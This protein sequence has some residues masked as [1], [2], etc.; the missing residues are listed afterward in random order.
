MNRI[1]INITLIVLAFFVAMT[2]PSCSNE[3]IV[4]PTPPTPTNN[5]DDPFKDGEL[6]I[7]LPVTRAINDGE[8]ENIIQTARLIVIKNSIVANNKTFTIVNGQLAHLDSVYVLDTIPVGK[9]DMFI[10]VNEKT[11]WGLASITKNSIYF[12]DDISKKTLA[13]SAYPA[14]DATHPIPMYKQYRDLHISNEGAFTPAGATAPIP[15]A[16]LGEVERLYAKVT[17]VL[18][19]KFSEMLNGGDPIKID[20]IS[21]KSMP[22]QSYLTPSHGLL[23]PAA[24]GGYFDGAVHASIVSGSPVG[25][26]AADAV[27][28]Y[29]SLVWYIPEH[30][31]SDTTYLTYISVKASLTDNTL[32]GEQV[33][34]KKIIL[35]DSAS[36]VHQDSL[37]I[38]RNNNV[39]LPL[40]SWFI[41]RNTHYKVNATIKSFDKM[42]ESTIDVITKVIVWDQVP[43]G[44]TDIREYELKVSQDEFHFTGS[45]TYEGVVTVETNYPGGW[46]AE[47]STPPKPSAGVTFYGSNNSALSNPT[48]LQTGNQLRFSSTTGVDGGYIDVTAGP[49][50]KRINLRRH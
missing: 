16:T 17:L 50:V 37:R 36:T 6:P 49:I 21:I 14:V 30:R 43:I 7:S 10:I 28:L 27:G 11:E 13:F 31:L 15:M 1:L 47:G 9:V 46:S 35:G 4:D 2:T 29:D 22:K 38:A 26:Y 12:P 24:P 19:A 32:P 42:N 5:D 40:T 3:A 39:S 48:P 44:D 23:Y 34:F 20:S 25:N 8:A 45:G 33:E 18:K 41:T